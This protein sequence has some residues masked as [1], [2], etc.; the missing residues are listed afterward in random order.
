MD[1]YWEFHTHKEGS[2]AAS[3][4]LPQALFIYFVNFDIFFYSNLCVES[5]AIIQILSDVLYFQAVH[6]KDEFMF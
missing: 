5:A 6:N 2:P 4:L 3:K 1:I